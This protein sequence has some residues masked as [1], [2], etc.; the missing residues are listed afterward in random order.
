MNTFINLK[1]SACAPNILDILSDILDKCLHFFLIKI[2]SVSI[3]SQATLGTF[4]SICCIYLSIKN[5][6]CNF[7]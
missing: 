2:E 7:N 4:F 6:I 5:A 1:L 3:S